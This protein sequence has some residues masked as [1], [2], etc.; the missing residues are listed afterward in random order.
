MSKIYINYDL[1][2]QTSKNVLSFYNKNN[3]SCIS[4]VIDSTEGIQK[5]SSKHDD[6]C[7]TVSADS[8]LDSL[9]S[10][11]DSL[12][13]L[14]S[15]VDSTVNTYAMAETLLNKGNLITSDGLSSVFKENLKNTK[16]IKAGYYAHYYQQILDSILETAQGTRSKTVAAALFLSTN[17]PHLPYFWGGGHE[18]IATGVD[19]TWGMEKEV[20]AEGHKTSGT[21]QSNSLD[22]SGYVSWALKNGG[23]PIKNPMV[24][25][26]LEKIGKVTSLKGSSTKDILPGDLTY[27]DGHIGMV[28]QSSGDEIT[29]SHCSSSGG[30]MGLTT[31]NVTTGK[32][33]DDVLYP[34]R[35]GKDYFD[36]IIHVDYPD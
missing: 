17:F 20:T 1:L 26:D 21:C 4:S 14:V 16:E 11:L 13:G 29:I 23:Y 10:S 28:V 22:C 6:F 31:M 36:R 3:D 32:V 12:L 35:V 34:Y 19:P 9:K 25:K 30:G 5:L 7:G 15:K 8:V 2:M 27:M 18:K 24:T 33:T